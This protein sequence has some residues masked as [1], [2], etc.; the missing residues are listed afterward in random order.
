M[1]FMTNNNDMKLVKGIN[2]KNLDN[3]FGKSQSA[4]PKGKVSQ[5]NIVWEV[6]TELEEAKKGH[7]DCFDKMNWNDY[8]KNAVLE[9]ARRDTQERIQIEAMR[10]NIKKS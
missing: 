5:S 2:D 1:K 8:Q 6:E 3:Y 4:K 10:A 9:K 7:A